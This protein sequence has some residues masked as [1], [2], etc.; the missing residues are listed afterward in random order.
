MNSEGDLWRNRRLHHGTEHIQG[1]PKVRLICDNGRRRS[2]ADEMSAW[3][4]V[5][6]ICRPSES[7]DSD[8]R[9]VERVTESNS[10]LGS[11]TLFRD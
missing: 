3:I 10:A 2:V 1:R 9:H 7:Q 11:H 4:E 8:Q 5:D 6:T